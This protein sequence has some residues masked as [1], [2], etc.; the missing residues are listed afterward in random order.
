MLMTPAGKLSRG[1]SRGAA[2][3]GT[4][5]SSPRRQTGPGHYNRQTAAEMAA[6]R[7]FIILHYKLTERDDTPFWRRCRDMPIPDSLAERLA[8]FRDAAQAY[9][10]GE[11]LF[12]VDSWVSVMLGQRLEPR[13]WHQLARLV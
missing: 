2:P 3:V 9:Q 7:D 10:G 4:P 1:E 5:P 12:R 6:V 13:A 11:D 8:L